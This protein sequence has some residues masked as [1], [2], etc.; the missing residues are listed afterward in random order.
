VIDVQVPIG[1][2]PRYLRP[3]LTSFPTRRSFLQ[4]NATRMQF[5]RD[6]LDRLGS[7][8]KIGIAWR[9]GSRPQDRLRRSAPL[10][11]WQSLLKCPGAQFVSLEYGDCEA[12]VE[13]CRR[14][15]GTLH[16]LSDISPQN[17]LDEL[18]ATIGALDLVVSV[19]NAGTHL[20][21]ALGVP[22][23]AMLPRYQG[24]WW[25]LDRAEMPWYPNVRVLR[26]ADDGAWPGLLAMVEADF[27][28][29]LPA[30][31]DTRR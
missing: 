29:W 7:G 26:Q 16:T 6:R 3:A 9:A 23:W 22:T 17:N 4:A 30:N 24:W 20:A 18:A 13:A 31:T 27:L 15:G 2:L 14:A 5:W 10:A 8:P 12:E 28:N 19:A 11:H 25:P 1:D 21:G